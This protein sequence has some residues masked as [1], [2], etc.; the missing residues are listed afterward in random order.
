[1]ATSTQKENYELVLYR[2]DMIARQQDEMDKKLDRISR[3]YVTKEEFDEFKEDVRYQ[4]KKKTLWNVINPIIASV[5]TAVVTFLI[6]EFLR[7]K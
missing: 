5:S 7:S 6:I 3:H 4:L 2:L 1:M